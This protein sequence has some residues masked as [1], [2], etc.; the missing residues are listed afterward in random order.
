MYYNREADC[1]YPLLDS[2]QMYF[3][4]HIWNKI[5]IPRETIDKWK[6]RVHSDK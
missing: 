6:L 1:L 5:Y 3:E 4:E 2:K